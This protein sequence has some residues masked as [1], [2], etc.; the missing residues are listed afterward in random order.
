MKVS[1]VMTREVLTLTP[2]TPVSEIARLLVE[3]NIGGAPVVAANGQ[4]L[5]V[6]TEYDLIVRNAHLH[7]PTFFGFLD[8]FVP[9]RGQ[10]EFEEELRRALGTYARDVM[11]EHL[12]TIQSDA[13]LED[14]ATIMVDHRVNPLPVVDRG[15][16]VGIVSR[17]DLV[18][19][20]AREEAASEG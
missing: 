7:L 6:V 2:Q 19:L 5:G 17:S 12:Y 15:K 8:A 13:D 1:Q 9:V 11:S 3:H 14:A 4:V 10:H 20:M 16:L 18:R